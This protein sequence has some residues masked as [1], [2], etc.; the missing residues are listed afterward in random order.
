ML[1]RYLCLG[2]FLLLLALGVAAC[3]GSGKSSTAKTIVDPDPPAKPMPAGKA[4]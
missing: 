4:G 1:R 2:A 3:G